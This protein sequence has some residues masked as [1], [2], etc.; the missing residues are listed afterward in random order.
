MTIRRWEAPPCS[1]RYRAV[2]YDYTNDRTMVAEGRFDGGQTVTV[3]QEAY[4]PIP[5]GEEFDEAARI[6]QQDGNFADLIKAE[7]LKTYHP[8][9]DVTVLDGY[10]RA[11][12]QRRTYF[13]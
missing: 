6:V 8:M 5:S 13:Q 10:Y 12:R 2:F 4:Q 3:R 11:S 1:T 7:K 9:P